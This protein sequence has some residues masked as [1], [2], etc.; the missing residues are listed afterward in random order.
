MY[1]HCSLGFH[2]AYFM[3]CTKIMQIMLLLYSEKFFVSLSFFSRFFFSR[4]DSI[5]FL[6]TANLS[7]VYEKWPI[8]CDVY[9]SLIMPKITAR[10]QCFY[11][12]LLKP[13]FE[14]IIFVKHLTICLSRHTIRSSAKAIETIDSKTLFR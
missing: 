6:A 5:R 14:L 7:M 12:N 11:R 9:F 4:F 10:T 13:S 8:D 2:V 1:A 3:T